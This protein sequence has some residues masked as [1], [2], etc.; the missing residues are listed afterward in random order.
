M[1][2]RLKPS[3]NWIG[4]PAQ[5]APDLVAE[6]A[7]GVG[8]D[9]VEQRDARVGEVGRAVW[10]NRHIVDKAASDPVLK[11]AEEPAS[12]GV[13]HPHRAGRAAGQPEPALWIDLHAANVG[14]PVA[15]A[16]QE[17]RERALAT[18]QVAAIDRAVNGATGKEVAVPGMVGDPLGVDRLA[19]GEGVGDRLALVDERRLICTLASTAMVVRTS[20][21][22]LLEP[23][24]R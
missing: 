2:F 21:H 1:P 23:S 16:R 3:V 14:A 9:A 8:R 17:R 7:L 13:V 4:E 22:D 19:S 18:A 5:V 10:A 20:T 24:H 11:P 6:D 15:A 12:H